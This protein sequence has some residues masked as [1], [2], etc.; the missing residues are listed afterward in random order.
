MMSDGEFEDFGYDFD[1]FDVAD[2]SPEDFGEELAGLSPEDFGEELAGLSPEMLA[3][4][5]I[6]GGEFD[7]PAEQD[8]D[9]QV[10]DYS[11]GQ[12]SPLNINPPHQPVHLPRRPEK[13]SKTLLIHKFYLHAEV[14]VKVLKTPSKR[15]VLKGA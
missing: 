1:D 7:A 6:F 15:R 9:L 8:V 5:D 10:Q 12:L 4:E 14:E 2:L 11:E 3:P 13:T